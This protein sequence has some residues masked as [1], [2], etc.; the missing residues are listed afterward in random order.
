MELNAPGLENELVRLEPIGEQHWLTI[1]TAEIQEAF[2][3]WMPAQRGGAS[4]RAYFDFILKAQAAGLAATFVLF[5]QSDGAFAGITGMNEINKLHRRVRIAI[6]WHPPELGSPE[7]YKAGQLAMIQRAYD[8]RAK[9]V[10]WQINPNNKFIVE[11]LAKIGPTREALFRNFERTADG[12]WVDKAIFSMTRPEM[13]QAIA[14]L[15]REIA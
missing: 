4:L 6:A 8:W 10:E 5:R 14:R 15:E 3:R 2:W 7:L 12:V 11:E 1:N 13:A 9:R